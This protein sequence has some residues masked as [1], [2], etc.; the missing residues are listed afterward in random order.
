MATWTYALA[1]TAAALSGFGAG[2]ITL[3]RRRDR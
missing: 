3:R 1:L 2:E